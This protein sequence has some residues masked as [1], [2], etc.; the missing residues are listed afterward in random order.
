MQTFRALVRDLSDETSFL[1]VDSF[2]SDRG[3]LVGELTPYPR[4]GLLLRM[5]RPWDAWFGDF[6][7]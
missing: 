3:V 1:R 4:A 2:L 7:T 5:P 6:W